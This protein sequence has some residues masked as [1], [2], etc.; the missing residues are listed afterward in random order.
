MAG[1][2]DQG[3]TSLNHLEAFSVRLGLFLMSF[4]FILFYICISE[5]DGF[6]SHYFHTSASSP[7]WKHSFGQE[8]HR[9]WQNHQAP[10]GTK[11][12][13]APTAPWLQ[14]NGRGL[15]AHPSSLG[16]QSLVCLGRMLLCGHNKTL[17]GGWPMRL[18]ARVLKWLINKCHGELTDVAE[19]CSP[20]ER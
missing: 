1:H 3:Q 14:G 11:I 7:G 8:A 17:L 19:E 2:L 4:L 16:Q 9:D 13:A 18:M 15:R 12:A 5:I 6:S 20:Q 10:F